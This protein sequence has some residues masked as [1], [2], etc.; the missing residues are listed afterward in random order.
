MSQEA[1]TAEENLRNAAGNI[2]LAVMTTVPE[3]REAVAATLLYGL[4][5]EAENRGRAA[6]ERKAKIW[7]E[8]AIASQD[9]SDKKDAEI[10]RLREALEFYADKWK[11]LLGPSLDSARTIEAEDCSFVA[12]YAAF[13]G[14][15]RAREALSATA[16]S[17][18]LRVP[19]PSEQESLKE[20]MRV[21]CKDHKDSYWAGCYRWLRT[22]LESRGYEIQEE[23]K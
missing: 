10:L 12:G 1:R 4:V 21:I 6:M 7:A 18:K 13:T 20:F 14:G 11:W 5:R 16:S 9:S 8:R 17:A 15:K 22:W 3:Q 23:N 19:W 2:V